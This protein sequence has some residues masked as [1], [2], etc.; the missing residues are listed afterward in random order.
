[1]FSL[2]LTY[3]GSRYRLLW[4]NFNIKKVQKIHTLT[5]FNDFFLAKPK[6]ALLCLLEFKMIST[7][8]FWDN[9]AHYAACI[10]SWLPRLIYRRKLTPQI[11]LCMESNFKPLRHEGPKQVT[12]WVV[13]CCLAGSLANTFISCISMTSNPLC[14]Q[15]LW[16][17]L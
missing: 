1:M 7:H 4:V 3:L 11:K 13:L 5:F 15:S 12:K 6:K 8:F 14:L 9:M 16:C 17:P 10:C 2:F